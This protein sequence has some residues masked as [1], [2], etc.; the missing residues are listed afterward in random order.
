MQFVHRASSCAEIHVDG[1]TVQLT[2]CSQDHG[3]TSRSVRFPSK[4]QTLNIFFKMFLFY[5]LSRR[6]SRDAV[7]F[8][9]SPLS[10]EGGNT[11]LR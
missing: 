2:V 7:S 1:V 11:Y 5:S 9:N 8:G 3:T 4:L 10:R 6:T